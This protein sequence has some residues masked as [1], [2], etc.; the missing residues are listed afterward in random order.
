MRFS[1]LCLII[2]IIA[3]I[4]FSVAQAED[5]ASLPSIQLMADDDLRDEVVTTVTPFQEDEKVRKALQHQIIKKEQDIQN[6]TFHD[7]MGALNVQPQTPLPDMSQLTPLQQEYV[8]SVAA[9][10][11]S[12]DPSSGIFKILEPLGIDREKALNHIQHGGGA[13]QIT[14]DEQ[15]LNQLFGDQWRGGLK[16]D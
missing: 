4:P 16:G 2:S 7:Q 5:V 11:K 10:F 6:T 1:K 9:G 15:R 14:F 3:S 13:I 8:L 12:A